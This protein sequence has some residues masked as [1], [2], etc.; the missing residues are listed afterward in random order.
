MERFEL[1]LIAQ[2]GQSVWVALIAVALICIAVTLLVSMLAGKPIVILGSSR[3]DVN[4]SLTRTK[5]KRIKAA[6]AD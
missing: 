2:G 3:A 5:Q 4:A 6:R 1:T